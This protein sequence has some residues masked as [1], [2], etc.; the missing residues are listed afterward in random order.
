MGAPPPR[1]RGRCICPVL[2]LAQHALVTL[3]P[4]CVAPLHPTH[5]HTHTFQAQALFRDYTGWEPEKPD[6]FVVYTCLDPW[7]L[8]P[9]MRPSKE[10]EMRGSEVDKQTTEQDFIQSSPT[11]SEETIREHPCTADQ[12]YVLSAGLPCSSC[13]W[14]GGVW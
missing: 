14:G 4:S 7:A 1:C 6:H 10:G 13:P 2:S 9:I 11:F 8:E 3:A 12:S 5:P